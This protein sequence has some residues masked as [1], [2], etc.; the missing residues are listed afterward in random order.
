MGASG[1]Y[2]FFW[3]KNPPGNGR[4]RY[5][6]YVA[7][8]NKPGS[9]AFYN[10]FAEAQRASA[11]AAELAAGAAKEALNDSYREK[12]EAA[13]LTARYYAYEARA[14]ETLSAIYDHVYN[15]KVAVKKDDWRTAREWLDKA[16][17]FA[18]Q[19]RDLIE[20]LRSI[21]QDE[22]PMKYPP[23]FKRELYQIDFFE[24]EILGNEGY[25]ARKA[26]LLEQESSDFLKVDLPDS[27]AGQTIE[28][29]I[30]SRFVVP[31]KP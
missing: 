6:D 4:Y 24:K 22:E 15:A 29:R 5:H 17:A 8:K 2:S 21:I 14:L 25:L 7:L 18:E 12:I 26:T 11:E 20:Q 13:R 1:K 23:K 3:F 10:D 27:L 19:S 30:G 28:E 31:G 16:T 9:K